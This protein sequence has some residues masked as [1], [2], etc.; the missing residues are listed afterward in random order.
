MR[1]LFKD[2][3]DDHKRVDWLGKTM[4][5]TIIVLGVVIACL[6]AWAIA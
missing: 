5:W 4:D 3:L 2:M 1:Q 6:L